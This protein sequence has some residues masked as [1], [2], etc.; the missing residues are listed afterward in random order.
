MLNIHNREKNETTATITVV[1]KACLDSFKTNT[2]QPL[3][4]VQVQGRP[5]G[6]VQGR[7]PG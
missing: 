2:K 4:Q 3:K 7:P 5:P 6:Q 1:I